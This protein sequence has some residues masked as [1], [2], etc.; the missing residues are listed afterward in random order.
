MPIRVECTRCHEVTFFA[1]NDAGLAVACVR[2]KQRLSVPVPAP[3]PKSPAPASHPDEPPPLFS[4]TP[5]HLLVA[6]TPSS[7]AQSP[8]RQT[9]TKPRPVRPASPRSRW[10]MYTLLF[11]AISITAGVALF[12]KFHQDAPVS[13]PLVKETNP[14]TQP[15]SQP[16]SIPP[17]KIV[18]IAKPAATQPT[19]PPAPAP[20]LASIA[21]DPKPVQATETRRYTRADA[22][23]GF[24]GFERVDLTGRINIDSYNSAIAPYSRDTALGNATLLSNGPIQ[25]NFEGELRGGLHAGP[26]TP[27]FKPR[28]NL[29]ITGATNPLTVLLAAPPVALDPFSHDS[30]NAALPK[31]FF[32]NGNLNINGKHTAVIPAGVYYLNDFIIDSAATLRLQG[33]ATLLISGQVN[34]VGTIETQD[35]RPAFCRIRLTSDKQVTITHSNILHLDLYAPQSPINISG[36]GELFGSIVGRTLAITGSRDLHFDESLLPR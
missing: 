12:N 34:I 10:R 25:P 36:K 18:A 27:A 28:R 1:D 33:P 8:A 22:P 29:T 26:A 20:I 16:I 17:T 21:Q 31:E 2:C 24:I 30:A 23:V 32:K 6:S 3:A 11:A 9:P 14:A 4:S 15:A 7:P 35:N 5:K 13:S 19:T